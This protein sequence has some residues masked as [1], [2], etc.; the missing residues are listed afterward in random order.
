MIEKHR[1][2]FRFIAISGYKPAEPRIG[3]MRYAAHTGLG[4]E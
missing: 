3:G 4:V 2:G 1:R